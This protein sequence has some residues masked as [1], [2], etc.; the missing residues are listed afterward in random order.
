MK[1]YTERE[2]QRMADV[3]WSSADPFITNRSKNDILP[4]LILAPGDG[5]STVS[6]KLVV[7]S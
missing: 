1:Q 7:Q 6:I 2:R 5:M 4:R 3:V